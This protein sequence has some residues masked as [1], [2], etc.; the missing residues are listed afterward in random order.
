MPYD[1]WMT[2]S[3]RER[4]VASCV[5]NGVGWH[6][7][8]CITLVFENGLRMIE[9][10]NIRKAYRT[11]SF[12]QVALDDVSLAFRD[13]EFVAVLG[14]SGS[15]KTTLLNILGGLDHADSGD[16]VING[17]STREYKDADWDTYRNHR[18]GFIFQSYNLIPHQSIKSNVELALTLSGVSRDERSRRAIEALDRVGLGEHVNKRPNQLSG[19]QMQ[20]VAIARALIN[21]PDIVLAD[22]PTG[23]LDTETGIQVM[24]LL[25]EIARDRL[26][27]MVTHNP[28]LA[29]EYANRIVSLSDGRVTDDTNP[30]GEEEMRQSLLAPIPAVS[31]AVVTT[32]ETSDGEGPV[33]VEGGFRHE[34]AAVAAELARDAAKGSKRH[35]S[36]S[37]LTALALSFENLMT[38]K[39]RTFLTAFAGSIGIIGIAAILALSNGVNDYIKHVEE[40]A[41]SSYPLSITKTS[42]NMANLMMVG[43]DVGGGSSSAK[44]SA[45]QSGDTPVKVASADT[46]EQSSIMGDIFAEVKNNDL[47]SFKKYLESGESGIDQYV[48]GIRYSYNVTP[49]VYKRDTSNGV[50]KLNPSPMT[51]L[52]SSGISSSALMGGGG[53]TD[54][55]NEITSSQDV[56]DEQMDVVMGHWPEKYDEA[57]LVLRGD[58]HI[59]DYSLYNMGIYDTSKMENMTRQALEGKEVEIPEDHV[60]FSYEDA[61]GLTFSVVPATDMYKKNADAG[62][63]ADMSGDSDFMKDAIDNGVQLKIVGVVRP[64]KSDDVSSMMEGVAYSRDLTEHLMQHAADSQIVKEQ[65]DNPDVDV[66]TGKTFEQLKSE[67]GSKFDME[68]MFSIDEDKI[69]Q[70]FKFDTS[71][72]NNMNL[73]LDLS[74]MSM[75]PGAMQIDSSQMQ[76][77]PSVISGIFGEDAFIKIMAG[78]PKFSLQDAG[79]VGKDLNLTDEQKAAAQETANKLAG[80]FMSWLMINHKIVP[81]EEPDY[82]A[83]FQEYLANDTDAQQSMADLQAVLGDTAQELVNSAM[84]NYLQNQF[85]PYISAQMQ[86]LM[87]TAAQAMANQMAQAMATQMA[88]M[89]DSLGSTLSSAISGQ[90]AS[91]MS[92]LSSALENGFSFDADAFADAISVNMDQSDL[93]SLLSNFKNAGDLSY[94]GNLSKLGYATLDNP[95]TINIYPIDFA[96]KDKVKEIIDQYNESVTVGDDDS[97]AIGY[98]DLVGTLM[99]SVT[100]IVNM[101]SLVLVAFVSISLVVSS[102]MIGIITYISVLER[103]KEIGILRAIGASKTNIANV[104]NAETVIEGLMSGVFAIVVVQLV[105]IPVNAVVAANYNIERVLNLPWSSALILIGISV[106]LTFLA[107]LIPS[108]AASRRDPVEALRSE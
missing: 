2:A 81:G 92:Q 66:F 77:D 4:T 7:A 71:A 96:A 91:S 9:L 23:A 100:K 39:G 26:V 54:T 44:S 32:P 22:E 21:D 13:N 55:F 52:V 78:A 82:V 10:R 85:A 93:T 38:K 20:R 31:P 94:D 46:I 95:D 45:D 29:Q 56:L 14:P 84:Q 8:A 28:E 43:M 12:T 89:T 74:G 70:A 3:P 36:M 101:I 90:L 64:K 18:I 40:N 83:L 79:L 58:G 105:S 16:I 73:D 107:G 11:G 63:W 57:V 61:M 87:Q 5:Y 49:Q 68:S 24:D 60:D 30:F 42:F 53:G 17:V 62:T 47:A 41:L 59:S 27:I 34:D 15:G 106:L 97:K 35:A 104:F 108:T 86:A 65:L 67:E 102:I 80:G 1:G 50:V 37:F 19:G 51:A 88:A 99:K 103:R 98:S 75:D 33:D 69:A 25:S 6:D 72:L 48:S 76:I